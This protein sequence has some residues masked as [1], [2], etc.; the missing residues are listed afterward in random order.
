MKKYMIPLTRGTGRTR[1][2]PKVAVLLGALVMFVV[3]SAW[4]L[5]ITVIGVD[6]SVSPPNETVVD[7]YRWVVEEDQT[8]HVQL[9]PSGEVSRGAG[10]I[11]VIDPNWPQGDTLSV[12][13]HQS[14]VPVVAKGCVNMPANTVCNDVPFL[15]E[16]NKHYFVTVLPLDGYAMGGAQ[17]APNQNN[18]VVYV[19]KMPLPTAQITVLVHED[20]APINA[21]WSQNERG[22]EGFRIVL[23]DGGGRYGISA[24]VQTKDAFNNPLGTTYL[25]P[26]PPGTTQY[27]AACIDRLGSSNLYTDKDGLLT[28]KN[29]APGKYGIIVVPPNARQVLDSNGDPIP[30]EYES[31]DWVQTTT[32]EGKKVID[33]WV[34]NA[35]PPFFAEFGPP[36]PHVTIGFVPAGPNKPLVDNQVLTG[37]ASISGQVLNLHLSRPPET[38][39]HAGAPFSQ[40]IPWVGLNQG[41]AGKGKAVYAAQANE[42]GSFVIPNVPPGNYQLVIWDKA[43]DLIFASH[44]VTV[45]PDMSCNQLMDCAFGE[46]PVFQWF[47]RIENHVFNDANENGFRDA[48]EGPLLEQNINLRWRDGSIYQSFPTDAEGFVPFDE[49]FPFF[50]WLV[51]EVDFAR[52]KATGLTV[53][54]DDGGAI[55]P[56]DPWSWGGQLNP[57]VQGNPVDLDSFL[58]GDLDPNGVPYPAGNYRVEVGSVLTQGFL[59]FLGQ[60]TVFEW[61]KKAYG[62]NENG[63]ISGVVMYAVTRAEDR[64]ELAAAEPW[65][66]GIPG[67]TVNL[68]SLGPD[69][70]P[71]TADD[72]LL[73]TTVTD[74]WDENIPNT[75]QYGSVGAP[76]VFRG[77]AIDCYDNM[78]NWNQVRPGVFDGGYAFGPLVDCPIA[79]GCPDWVI[80][81]SDPAVGYMKPGNYV[82]EVVAPEGYEIIR[83]Q[84]KNVDFG[85][86]YSNGPD[87]PAP[88]CV[89]NEYKVP[90]ELSLFPGV[91][92][93]LANQVLPLCDKKLVSVSPGANTAADFYLFTEVPVAS[94]IIGFILDDLS[95]EFDPASPQFGEKYAPPFMPVSIRDWTG[96][97][98]ARTYS[99]EF[100]RYNA[101]VPSTFTANLGKPSGVS[102][103]MLVAC[104]NAKLKADGTVDPLHNPQYS[105]FCYTLQYMP[106]TTTYLDTP[107]IPVAAFTG[108]EQAPLDCELIEGSPRI[109]SVSVDG[110]GVGGGPWVPEDL[111]AAGTAIV[112]IQSMGNVLVPNPAYDGIGGTEPKT[113]S[114]DYGFGNVPG[115]VTV[116]GV[117]LVDV[118]WSN[119]SITGRLPAGIQ[120]GQLVVTRGDNG[121]ASTTGVTLQVG[122]RRR[123]NVITVQQGQSIQDAIDVA[124][125]NDLILVG[126]GVYPE[127]VIMW[128]PVQLQGWGEGST[129][130]DAL[131]R[132]G[133][134]LLAWR[135]RA[136]D[137]VDSGA[138]SLV[139]GQGTGTGDIEPALLFAE[140]GA[141]VLVLATRRGRNAF[142]RRNNRGARIDG[143][144]I[145]GADTGGG[146]VVNGYANYLEISNNRIV[147]NTGFYGGG[148]RVGH[149]FAIEKRRNRER[150]TDAHN[151]WVKIRYNQILQNGGL[152]GAGGGISMYTGSDDYEIARNLVCGNF[153]NSD[154]AGIAHQG[155]SED[156]VIADNRILF[157]ENFNQGNTVNGGG[158]LISGAPALGCKKAK[159]QGN[160]RLRLTEGS[161]SVTVV[162][163]LIQGNA[164][165]AGDGGGIRV[166]QANGQDLVNFKRGGFTR[167]RFW[168]SVYLENN[169]IVDNVAALAGAGVSLQDTLK[170]RLKHNTIANND[171][172]SVAGEAFPPNS[173]DMSN[174]QP[175]AGV[176]ARIHSQDL[177]AFLPP[178][179]P[180]YSDPIMENNIVWQN[181]KFFWKSVSQTVFGLCPDIGGS[182]TGLNCGSN[183]PVYDDLAVLGV[184]ESLYCNGCLITGDPDPLFVAEYVNGNRQSTIFLPE[185]KT[186]IQAPPALDEGGNFIRLRYGPLSQTLLDGITLRGD[187]HIQPASPARDAGQNAGLDDDFDSQQR[188]QGPAPDIGADEIW[189]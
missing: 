169:I 143:F 73:D 128:K 67:V 54:V 185:S 187:Y 129:H 112:S 172:A 159:C 53:T 56:A 111:A 180:L 171:N 55:D 48:G 110:N 186:A 77:N 94:H 51:A 50:S 76:Y 178:N 166:Y 38:P 95:N 133:S 154:G 147:N 160:A 30:G 139:P 45:N 167:P 36:G 60:T 116:G 132:T 24:G 27:D 78:R 164:A 90:S 18:V 41:V 125:R 37:G 150:H 108:P 86:N 121:N 93:P 3:Q 25:N 22:L 34:K 68:Y 2:A 80:P 9:D 149:P 137:L 88:L 65:E 106:G 28:I 64:P 81:T 155:R 148:V 13:M 31:D 69:N 40:T 8:Y 12:S 4:A 146:V 59:G 70:L 176:A 175:G 61:G 7:A 107:V 135:A 123:A 158:V 39:F 163:N 101:L 177:M 115:T 29:L 184:A 19:N 126:P 57:Q 114:R 138:V 43:L 127:M 71:N 156:G 120:T 122:L 173:P 118:S 33:A 109:Y 174:A 11:P 105:Q 119:S 188:P 102:P 151:G 52:F 183:L 75:C 92:A 82:V 89:G 66:P 144:T 170:T 162:R 62:P 130:I 131:K 15:Q 91:P 42:D 17:I 44:G 103:N 179:E 153:T 142:G 181:R 14:Y 145:S 6:N 85:E 84:D 23:E 136:R 26:C 35:E 152:T 96:R 20:T 100:G 182:I 189:P 58:A 79:I 49:V 157:N 1:K 134:Q 63:G 140:E 168:H 83:S 10:G 21:A 5:N 124:R 99:D 74:S 98:I 87:L 97:E 165:G 46:I 141:G 32:I 104:M 47:T 117:P 161:G 72:V 113:I 16:T